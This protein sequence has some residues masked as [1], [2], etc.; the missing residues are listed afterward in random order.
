MIQSV[1]FFLIIASILEIIIVPRGQILAQER[2]FKPDQANYLNQ[3]INPKS[4]VLINF[5]I[6]TPLKIFEFFRQRIVGLGAGW[7]TIYHW[8][9]EIFHKLRNILWRFKDN[10]SAFQ[11]QLQEK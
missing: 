2:P 10:F 8:V 1:K 6:K 3:T 11:L 9:N 7:Q 4:E 5:I